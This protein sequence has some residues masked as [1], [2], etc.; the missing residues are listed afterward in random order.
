MAIEK[1]LRTKNRK[2]DPGD[3]LDSPTFINMLNNYID[4]HKKDNLQVLKENICL[5]KNSEC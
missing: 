1:S 5:L 2:Q 4:K 3:F